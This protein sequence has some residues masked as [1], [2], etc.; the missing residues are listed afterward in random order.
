MC[1]ASLRG[2]CFDF[3][4][5]PPPQKE[6]E[7]RKR[8]KD[9][10]RG[11]PGKEEKGEEKSFFYVVSH[12]LSFIFT[13]TSRKRGGKKK[14]RKGKARREDL[15]VRA[16]QTLFLIKPRMGE[17]KKRGKASSRPSHTAVLR[18]LAPGKK[19]RK[20]KKRKKLVVVG[21]V[22]FRPSISFTSYVAVAELLEGREGGGEEKGSFSSPPPFCFVQCSA[23]RKQGKEGKKEGA[24]CRVHCPSIFL[25]SIAPSPCS[26]GRR[27]RGRR[28]KIFWGKYGYHHHFLPFRC[29]GE[30]EKEKGGRKSSPYY[31]SSPS[32]PDRSEKGRKGGKRGEE[33]GSLEGQRISHELFYSCWGGKKREKKEKKSLKRTASTPANSKRF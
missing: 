7:R 33:E 24:T 2:A 15:P 29:E 21:P 14:E 11:R 9:P 27:K 20:K 22:N 3:T 5:P 28:G 18:K 1:A 10:T 8:K 17:G 32:S 16:A 23:D 31:Y 12:Y 25:S 13:S 4:P 30:K 26:T 6:K 19:E